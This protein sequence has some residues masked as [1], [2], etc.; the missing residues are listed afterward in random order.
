MIVKGGMDLPVGKGE[1]EIKKKK[2]E[3]IVGER[4]R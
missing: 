4:E 1:S 3:V 2:K